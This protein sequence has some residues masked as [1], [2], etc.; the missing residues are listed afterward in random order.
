MKTSESPRPKYIYI[1][2]SNIKFPK[3]DPFKP[4]DTGLLG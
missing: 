1:V 3:T 4:K 2:D